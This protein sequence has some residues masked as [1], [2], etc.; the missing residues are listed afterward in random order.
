ME[1]PERKSVHVIR[2]MSAGVIVYNRNDGITRILLLEQNNKFYK[3]RGRSLHRRVIDIGPCGRVEKGES[4]LHAARREL[5]QEANLDL[6]IDMSISDSF[7]YRFN[8]KVLSGRLKG[9]KALII[10]TRKYFVSMASDSDL[11][12]LKLSDEHKSYMLIP[13]DKAINSRLLERSKLEMLK[14]MRPRISAVN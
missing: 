9:T 5:K 11:K 13:I 2:E 6:H 8:G 4:I 12:N 3:R 14:R 10:K 7:S 1:K